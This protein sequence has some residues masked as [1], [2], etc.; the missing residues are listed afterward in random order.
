MELREYE[1]EVAF[2][3]L[4]RPK[5]AHSLIILDAQHATALIKPRL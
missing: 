1:T 5:F 2:N 3:K 4:K